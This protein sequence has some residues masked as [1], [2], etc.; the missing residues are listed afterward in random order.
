MARSARKKRASEALVSRK[1]VVILGGGFAGHAL[2]RELEGDVDLTLV[3]PAGR[4]VYVPLMHEV[5]GETVDPP[6]VSRDLSQ[7]LRHA[8]VLDATATRVEGMHA[9]LSSGER[10][11]FDT[12]VVAVGAEPNDFG[13]PGVREHALTFQTLEDALRANAAIKQMVSECGSRVVIVGASFTGVE[14]A[15]EVWE[16]GRKLGVPL[17]VVLLDAL[18]DMF[19]KQSERFRARVREA[20]LSRGM[21]IRLS[22]RTTRIREG[23]V[24][25]ENDKPARGD[26]VFWCAGVRPRSLDGVDHRVRPTLQSVARDDV[27]VIGDAATFPKDAAV[28]KLAQTA[29]EQARVCAWNILYPESMRAYQPHVRGLVVSLGHHEAV[30]ELPGGL[31]LAG[32]LPWHV[33][34]MLYKAKIAFA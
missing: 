4:F 24:E 27:F 12:C 21:E 5:V 9:L 20:L 15:G 22:C 23:E 16:L 29:E 3:A 19:P 33:K 32:D 25:I 13:V 30:A 2:A 26:V 18:P 10:L 1:R 6:E 34:R 17:S 8:R 31:V 14:V 28:P 11:P 7:I